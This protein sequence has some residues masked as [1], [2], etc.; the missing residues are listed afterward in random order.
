VVLGWGPVE[1]IASIAVL[2]TLCV[3]PVWVASR[4][5]TGEARFDSDGKVMDDE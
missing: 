1:W 2:V 4:G 5:E 3:V